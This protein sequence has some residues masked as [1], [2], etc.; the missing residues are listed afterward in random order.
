MYRNVLIFAIGGTLGA[1]IGY[2]VAQKRAYEACDKEIAAYKEYC[3]DKIKQLEADLKESRT[4]ETMAK[5]NVEPKKEEKK[6]NVDVSNTEKLRKPLN[7]HTFYEEKRAN[8]EPFP[9]EDDEEEVDEDAVRDELDYRDGEKDIHE[10]RGA[11]IK[12]IRAEEFGDDCRFEP[13]T[14][15]YYAGDDVLATEEDEEILDISRTV[16]KCLDKYGFRSNAERVIYVRNGNFGADYEIQKVDGF[17]S[18]QKE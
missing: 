14:L 18:E 10:L 6:Q 12:L 2:F 4:N 1:G 17:F 16:G 11:G 8:Q 7:Y 15:F 3:D 13:K 5:L 9:G